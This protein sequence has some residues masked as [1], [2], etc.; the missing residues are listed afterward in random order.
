MKKIHLPILFLCL[1]PF[2]LPSPAASQPT[3]SS[4]TPSAT[5]IPTPTSGPAPR[6][7][8]DATV[9][10]A[11]SFWEGDKAEHI[12]KFK[13]TGEGTLVIEEVRTSCGCTAALVSNKNIEPGG[14]GEIKASFNT[15][16]YQGKQSKNIFVT[17]NDPENKSIQLQLKANIKSVAHFAPRQVFFR[18]VTRGESPSQVI[19]LVPEDAPFKVTGVTA[20]PA[21]YFQAKIQGETTEANEKNEPIPIEVTLSPDTPIGHHKGNLTVTTDHPRK[22]NLKAN[23]IAQVEGPLK[24]DPRMILLQRQSP[25]EKSEKKITLSR[26]DEGEFE[27]LDVSTGTSQLE[28]ELNAVKP[29][30]VY[31]ITVRL[32]EEAP[33]GRHK[34]IVTIETDVEDQKEI[35]I[36]VT[37]KVLK[38]KAKPAKP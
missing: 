18:S 3:P 31:E 7:E 26:K 30:R 12:F 27:I 23:L 16:R 17:T 36:P 32:K 37:A 34:G 29:S 13:N 38:A 25:E 2:L 1:L 4:P 11:G 10:D 33:E 24:Y 21:A 35:K 8:F 14:E 19:K 20:S 28:L 6:I 5:A 15:K 9:G 22:A